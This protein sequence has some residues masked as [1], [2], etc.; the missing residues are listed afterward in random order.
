MCSAFEAVNEC[1]LQIYVQCAHDL[2]GIY[3][4]DILTLVFTYLARFN[5][6]NTYSQK[7]YFGTVCVCVWLIIAFSGQEKLS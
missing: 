4:S 7:L 1:P 6:R 2:R 5:P 3:R